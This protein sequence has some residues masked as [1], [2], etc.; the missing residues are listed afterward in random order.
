MFFIG[1]GHKFTF[2]I[3]NKHAILLVYTLIITARKS[4]V[5]RF[6]KELEGY[7]DKFK[8]K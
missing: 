7:N 1:I 8:K 4:W 3:I 5:N 6:I 2:Y